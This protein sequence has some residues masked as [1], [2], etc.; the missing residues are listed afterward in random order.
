MS[1]ITDDT[2][3]G[4]VREYM[5]LN[6]RRANA[7]IRELKQLYRDGL[8]R[9]YFRKVTIRVIDSLSLLTLF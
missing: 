6:H 1:N 9:S 2:D 5:R 4:R 8:P 7:L 3:A